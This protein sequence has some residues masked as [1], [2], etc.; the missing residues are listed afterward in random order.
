[1]PLS[2]AN[3]LER[4]KH[5]TASEIAAVLGISPYRT[6][7]SV[8][9][10]KVGETKPFEGNDATEDGNIL[11][12]AIIKMAERATGIKMVPNSEL[13]I[14]KDFPLIAATTD[15]FGFTGGNDQATLTVQVKSVGPGA[16]RAWGDPTERIDSIPPFIVPQVIAEM[17]ATNLIAEPCVVAMLYVKPVRIYRIAFDQDLWQA[18][19]PRIEAFW[20][21]VKEGTP[22]PVTDYVAAGSW[23]RDHYKQRSPDLRLLSGPERYDMAHWIKIHETAKIEKARAELEAEEAAARIKECIGKDA[24]IRD[25]QGGWSA[26]WKA[27][28][29]SIAINWKEVSARAGASSEDI[30]AETTIKPGARRFLIRVDQKGE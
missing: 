30:A 3:K 22:P 16:I 2:E 13:S 15:A 23:I 21:H 11:E 6:A 14:C 12:P 9:S 29:D 17:A 1:M 28:K 7:Q 24:G 8:W 10:E 26:T 25:D 20:H 27:S 18:I 19:L 4:V 5:V